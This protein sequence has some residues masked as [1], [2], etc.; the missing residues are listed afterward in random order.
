MHRVPRVGPEWRFRW[1]SVAAARWAPSETLASPVYATVLA[2][3]RP[4]RTLLRGLGFRLTGVDCGLLELNL[5]F[6]TNEAALQP[7]A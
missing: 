5:D 1:S 4:A 6:A 3:N 7:A 2:E